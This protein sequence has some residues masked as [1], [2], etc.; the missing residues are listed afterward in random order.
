M[1]GVGDAD[2]DAAVFGR[3]MDIDLATVA[4]GL[5]GV[6][7]EVEEDLVELGWRAL[8]LG[9]VAKLAH[10]LDAVLQLVLADLQR[11]LDAFVDLEVV[12]A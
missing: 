8:D 5:R 12:V 9:Q 10:D 3:G 4:N 2:A 1:S 6:G 7:E 11:G